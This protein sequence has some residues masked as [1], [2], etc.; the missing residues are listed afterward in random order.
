MLRV[1]PTLNHIPARREHVV[2]LYESINQP[3][4]NI[5]NHGTASTGAFL[6]GTRNEHGYYTVFVY[7]HQP[8][9]RAVIIYVSEPRSL[10]AEQFRVEESEAV[11]FV[12]SMGFMVDSLHFRQL[13]SSEQDAIVARVP[14]FRPPVVTLD[15]YD[16]ADAGAQAH[17]VHDPVFGGMGV[18]G[19]EL[20]RR[21]GLPPQP[22]AP[23]PGAGFGARGTGPLQSPGFPP[24]P[25]GPQYGSPQPHPGMPLT[26]MPLAGMPLAGMPHPGMALPGMALP[27]A[28]HSGAVALPTG[29]VLPSGLPAP[30]PG[31]GVPGLGAGPS[32]QGGAPVRD[33]LAAPAPRADGAENAAALERMGRLLAAFGLLL[34]V[35]AGGGA[36]AS[37][38]PDPELPEANPLQSQ[39]DI[40]NQHL[41][42][43][44]WSDA[45]TAFDAV[46]K[47]ESSD[48]DAL[49]GTGLAF[50]QLGRNDDAERF[51]RRA[52]DADPKWSEPKNE[53]AGVL[54]RLQR[55]AEAEELLRA[56]RDD[57][58]YA[59]PEF[60]EHNLALALQCQGKQGEAV[61]LLGGL[62]TKKPHFCL[63]YLTLS[64]LSLQ[65]K[66]SEVAVKAC[67]DF[68][69]HCAQNDRIRDQV[70]SQHSA[71]CYLRSGMAY[72]QM[73]D[74]ES[75]RASFMRCIPL[76][77]QGVG[78]ECQDKLGMLPP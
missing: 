36:C 69:F 7:L 78:K 70:S 17:A 9:T 55:C 52:I 42:E 50:S 38:T 47:E 23:G 68:L 57:I 22:L 44:R 4:V 6:L 24:G 20:F 5:P 49:R 48:R 45:I 16:L 37:A 28:A 31:L 74:V 30:P 56:V 77:G 2:S 14:I 40:G 43:R 12:E 67:D 71:L 72:V 11:R 65:A 26:G 13:A 51:Y 33:P 64:Q 61:E 1:D 58:F 15:L 54:I 3:L 60:A 76:D 41:S 66:Q 73:G 39:I 27:G 19:G 46:L 32:P 53:L 18:A 63:G 29:G 21:A 10:T 25:H 34:W 59:T 75:A 8:E 62:V 35:G